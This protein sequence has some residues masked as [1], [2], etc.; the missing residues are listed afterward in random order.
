MSQGNEATITID[1][2]KTALLLIHWQ[3]DIATPGGKM[4]DNEY[5]RIAAAHNIENTQAVLKASREKGLLI[6]YVKA[7]H[8][9]DYPE[10]PPKHGPMIDHVIKVGGMIRNTWG[11]NIIAQ[12]KPLETEYVI[13][14][15]NPNCFS[16]TPLHLILRNK[17]IT[18]LVLTGIATHAAIENTAREGFNNGYFVYTLSDCV[19]SPSEENHN[20]SIKNIL[21]RMGAVIDSKTFIAAL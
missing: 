20:H 11:S 1:R 14:N 8:W 9:P 12:L 17:G 16:Y 19:N 10:L 21:P 7:S 13:E 3:N 4:A 5:P 18:E 6:I 15:Y 2:D